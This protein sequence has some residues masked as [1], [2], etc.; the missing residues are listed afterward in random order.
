MTL[1]TNIQKQ[2]CD[3]LYKDLSAHLFI[4]CF[5]YKRPGS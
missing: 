5:I 3:A 1:R 4:Y 2:I